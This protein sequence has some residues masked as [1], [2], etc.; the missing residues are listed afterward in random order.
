MGGAFAMASG[1]K[2]VIDYNICYH[3]INLWLFVWKASGLS[4]LMGKH[5][6]SHLQNFSPLLLTVIISTISMFFTEVSSNA[7]TSTIFLPI[8]KQ[9]VNKNKIQNL[10]IFFLYSKKLCVSITNV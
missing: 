7:A 3:E 2:V 10:V 6:L 5:L 9:L 4:Q 8:V 1:I